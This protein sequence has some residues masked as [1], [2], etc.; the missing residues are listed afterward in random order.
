MAEFLSFSSAVEIVG[1]GVEAFVA[2]FPQ[3]FRESALEILAK[4]GI[5]SPR[6]GQYYVL[7]HFLDAMKEIGQKYSDQM[8]FRV[9]QQ[10]ALHAKLPPDI[11]SLEKSLASIDVAY[12]MNHRAGEI[13]NYRY[14][15]EENTGRGMNK[16]LMVCANPYPCAFDRGVI[17]GF[18]ERFKPPQ[19]LDVVV[20]HDD[21]RPCRRS[22]GDS[23]TYVISW[24]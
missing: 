4:H 3:E 13:G 19:C 15:C 8:L 24:I 14:S 1:E 18:A 2:G 11:N 16:A 12:H 23:C 7:Q 10:I 22:G 9:G 20:R 6:P 5:P 17:E 21:S